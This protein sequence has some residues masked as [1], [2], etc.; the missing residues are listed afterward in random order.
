MAT[1]QQRCKLLPTYTQ[2]KNISINEKI[3][4]PSLH[5]NIAPKAKYDKVLYL[6]P[7]LHG[8]DPI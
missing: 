4:N 7:P 6:E 8:K 1:T 2:E 5:I 3:I